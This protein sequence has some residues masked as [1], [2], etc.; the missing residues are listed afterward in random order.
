MPWF[1][2]DHEPLSELVKRQIQVAD[3]PVT[4]SRFGYETAKEAGID[5]TYIPHGI[6]PTVF[7]PLN[8][9]AACRRALHIPED[10]YLFLMVAANKGFPSRKNFQEAIPAFAMFCEAHP[11][12]DCRLYIHT[13]PARVYK[14][15]NLPGLANEFNVADKMIWSNRLAMKAGIPDS[16]INIVY[17]AADQL[18][19]PSLAEG[20]GLPLIEAQAVGLPV[21]TTNFS[22]MPELT[23]NGVLVNPVAK[24]YIEIQAWWGV[25]VRKDI[26]AGM[27][28]VYSWDDETKESKAEEGR[29]FVLRNYAW[30]YVANAYWKP[31]LERV[32]DE[33]TGGGELEM[34]S[35]KDL[36]R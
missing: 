6:E 30:D 32:D 28:E 3:Y 22:S 8:D 21:V 29:K 14:G 17:N 13:D 1:P 36:A 15:V 5:T 26:C 23:K 34:V 12:L 10:M 35:L 20:F 2:V 11:E 33:L 16:Q 9:K 31:F 18:L 24:Y 25:P 4:Y 19:M 27:E 7:K